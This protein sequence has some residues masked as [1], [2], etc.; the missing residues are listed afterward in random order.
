MSVLPTNRQHRAS[1]TLRRFA[2]AVLSSSSPD[3]EDVATLRRDVSA[4]YLRFH[5][6]ISR[7]LP[8]APAPGWGPARL[9]AVGMIFNR[10]TGL[11]LG[12]PPSLL[13]RIAS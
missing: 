11:D 4:W 13:R 9:D 7:A 3:S 5:T 12:P 10:V 6:I 8:Q 1:E 2:I